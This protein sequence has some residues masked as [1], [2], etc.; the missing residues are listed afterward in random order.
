[1]TL[2]WVL[3]ASSV[4]GCAHQWEAVLDGN[5]Y[6][7]THINRYPV[8]ITAVDGVYSLHNPRY[9]DAG[10]RRLTVEAP[11]VAGMREPVRKE[12]D[13]HVKRCVRYWLAAQRRSSLSPDFELVID[14]AEPVPGCQPYGATAPVQAVMPA[15]LDKPI[16]VPKR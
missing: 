12:F 16:P 11:P 3:V 5:V 10:F 13:F 8:A 1:M 14:H 9:V 2:C 4:V 6:T 15:Q 7:R